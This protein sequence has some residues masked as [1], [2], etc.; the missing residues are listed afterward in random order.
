MLSKLPKAIIVRKITILKIL[1]VFQTINSRYASVDYLTN[2]IESDN[3][4]FGFANLIS[5][6]QAQ[7]HFKKR[8]IDIGS[9][10]EL[11]KQKVK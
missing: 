11:Y 5:S 6:E 9:L 1:I 2:K 7:L 4:A 10:V 8:I 3:N